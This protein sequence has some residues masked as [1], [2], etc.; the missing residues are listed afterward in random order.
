MT[1]ANSTK[2]FIAGR[3]RATLLIG[4]AIA[5]SATA[6]SLWVA[7][8]EGTLK[9]DALDG[10]VVLEIPEDPYGAGAVAVDPTNGNVWT[11]GSERLRGFDRDGV[12][13]LDIESSS[14]PLWEHPND[15]LVDGNAGNIWLN[16]GNNLYRL[17][18]SGEVVGSL[19][20]YGT[21]CNS[22][23]LDRE[24][25]RLWL[26]SYE[27]VKAYDAAFQEVVSLPLLPSDIICR[28][29]WDAFRDELWV[30]VNDKLRRYNSAGVT[31]FE[32]DNPA[33]LTNTN[34]LKPDGKGGL[35]LG[36][37]TQ[38]VY[39]DPTGAVGSWITP[40]HDFSYLFIRDAVVHP[41]DASIWIGNETHLRRFSTAGAQLQDRFLD[42]GDGNGRYLENMDIFEDQSKPIIEFSQPANNS[43]TNQ[44][45]PTL[46]LVFLDSG[47]GIDDDTLELTINE[48]PLA[49]SCTIDALGAECI[50]NAA[51][52]D[53]LKTV[54]ARISDTSGN[55]SDPATVR[56]TVDTVAP[57][58][59]VS[60]PANGATTNQPSIIVLGA[61]S[62]PAT[63]RINGTLVGL[64][65][66]NNFS[67]TAALQEGQNSLA[68]V[69]TDNATNSST[70]NRSV[71]LD[72]QAPNV[73]DVGFIGVSSPSGGLVTITGQAGSV[74]ANALVQV[75]NLRTG[76][77]VTVAAT[78]EG[79]FV[80]QIA[81]EDADQL[82]IRAID[83][84]QNTSNSAQAA[85]P[86]NLPPNPSTIATPLTTTGITPFAE[87]IAFLYS[88]PNPIQ[89]GV[90]T[91]TI[92]SEL[93]AVIRGSVTTRTG[94]PLANVVVAIK[95]HPEFGQ[96]R[97]RA[98]GRFDL[99]VNGG[100]VLTL[101]YQRN[102]YLPLHRNV[103]TS[104]KDYVLAG[105][106]V[107]IQVDTAVSEIALNTTTLQSHQSSVA[108]DLDGDRRITLMVPPGTTATM[109][110]PDG[111]T[112]P[113][114]TSMR[115]RATEYT[116][117]VNG[118]EAM[119]APLPPTSAYT[120]AVELSVDEAVAAGARRVD[121]NQPMPVYLENFLN[122]PVGTDVPVGYYDR[123]LATW[124][125]SDNG[126]V[127]RIIAISGGL[128]S[129][130]VD[131]SNQ[132][133]GP[134]ELT[135]LG[136]TSAER[137]RL[138][139]L[140][141][142]GASFWRFRVTHFTP[143][144]CNFP[145]DLLPDATAPP[146]F[147]APLGDPDSSESDECSG[148]TIDAHAQALGESIDI[149][150]TPFTIN[151]RSDRAGRA[152]S[153]VEF[154]I[155]GPQIAPSLAVVLVRVAIGG[156]D[157]YNDA[158]GSAYSE[159]RG[160]PT[161][162]QRVSIA[163]D[164]L[165]AYGRRMF[166]MQRVEI[167]VKYGYLPEYTSV[168]GQGVRAFALTSST[169]TTV[170]TY[171]GGSGNV[172]VPRL[173]FIERKKEYAIR[174]QTSAFSQLGG[175]TINAHHTLDTVGNTLYL[176]DG[177]RRNLDLVSPK[178]ERTLYGPFSATIAGAAF[179]P[180][181]G[182]A[183]ATSNGR[184]ILNG[185]VIAGG[186][187]AAPADNVPAATAIFPAMADV[188]AGPYENFHFI[189][190]NQVWRLDRVGN[191][192]RVAGTGE[193]GSAGDGGPARDAS[194][195]A[196]AGIAVSPDGTVFVSEPSTHR[197]R[198]VGPDGVIT[199]Y[200]GTGVGGFSGDGGAAL[201]AQLREPRALAHAVDGSLFVADTA[202]LRVRR[203][204]ATGTITTVA[205]NGSACADPLATC[206]DGGQATSAMFGAVRDVAVLP[207]RELLIADAGTRRVRAVRS[208][209]VI[210]TIAGSGQTWTTTPQGDQS[211]AILASLSDQITLG[212]DPVGRVYVGDRD[213]VRLVETPRSSQTVT[214]LSVASEDGRASYQF[215]FAGRH[216][217]TV[218]TLTG[219]EL[220]RFSYDP[221]G[222]ITSIRDSNDNIT[223]VERSAT[224]APVAIVSPYG[225]RTI[226]G[227][228][229]NGYLSSVEPPG[230]SVVQ[231]Q[232][233]ALGLLTRFTDARN[234]ASVYEYD[235]AGRLIRDTNP[236]DGGWEIVKTQTPSATRISM[237]SREGRTSEFTHEQTVNGGRTVVSQSS[238]G[239]QSTQTMS[240]SGY[241]YVL[242]DGTRTTMTYA[243]DPRFGMQAP[244]PASTTVR[245][246]SGL[247]RTKT[248]SRSVTLSNPFDPASI[249]SI[250][251]RS[252]LNGRESSATYTVANRQ[253]VATSAEGRTT[254]STFDALGRIASSSTAG[255]NASVMNYDARGR[256]ATVEA[257]SGAA[258]R[259][260]VFSYVAEGPAAGLVDTITD[261][262]GRV[263]RLEYDPAGRVSRQT[264]PGNRQVLYNHDANGNLLSITPPGRSAHV[265]DYSA[266]NLPTIYAPPAAGLP[267]SATTYAYNR[268]RQLTSVVRPGGQQMSFEYTA[269]GK[270]ES[271][272]T[273]RGVTT[274]SYNPATGQM[275][276]VSTPEGQA[277]ALTFDGFLPLSS[278]WSGPVS[279][280]VSAG[281][282]SD[283]MLSSISVNGSGITFAYDNDRL[284]TTAGS[285]TI[286]R[287]ASNGL[288]SG[289]ALNLVTTQSGYNGFGE[290]TSY[291]ASRPTAS[292]AET[293]DQIRSELT[294]LGVE[295]NTV[296]TLRNTSLA[297]TQ[298]NNL[299]SAAQQ[300]PLARPGFNTAHSSFRSSYNVLRNSALNQNAC[301][302]SDEVY[303]QIV[304]AIGRA[305]A[306][307]ARLQTL[308]DNLNSGASEGPVF[309]MQFLRDRLGRITSKTEQV[310]GTQVV[311]DYAYDSAGR[312][313]QVQTNG[314]VS[315]SYTYDAN[316]NRLTA[317]GVGATYDDQDRLL[318]LGSV[319]FTY[320]AN[321]DL[322]T[323]TQAGQT[324][325]YNYDVL[326][327][328]MG[329]Q[330]PDGRAVSYVVDGQ[331]RRVGKRINGALVQGYLY[332]GQLQL[333]AELDG[334]GSVV[335]R[336]VYGTKLTV[337][338]YM[339]RSG[340]TYR[341][342]SDHLGSP[343]LVINVSSGQVVQR[344][345][346]DSFGNVTADTNPGFQPFGFAG[347]LHDRDT[348]LIRFGSRDYD[349]RVGRWTAKDPILFTGG[350]QNLYGYT[351]ADPINLVDPT[352]LLIGGFLGQMLRP[353][354]GQTAQEAAVAG[355]ALDGIAGPTL[356][357]MFAGVPGLSH[358]VLVGLSAYQAV[359][360]FQ[361]ASLSLYV[362]FGMYGSGAA[363]VAFN[364]YALLPL[365]LAGLG[366]VELGLGLYELYY[367]LTGD[368]FGGDIYDLVQW[369][370][371]RRR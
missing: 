169:G 67:F 218:D 230:G 171:R 23:T 363:V 111:S 83:A 36:S 250:T 360:G 198:R 186:G 146:D 227:L 278:I 285:L 321:G 344:V 245:V 107:M 192:R 31:T 98:D 244:V 12:S 371:C 65:G 125:A 177:S 161:P 11:W 179:H 315:E 10:A 289:T 61:L 165:D 2:N 119:P 353:L 164:G 38:F 196:P 73:P 105:N 251:E 129:L 131:G 299:V 240:R 275:S 39:I 191:L 352:G 127:V 40:F 18:L 193:L 189:A 295:L 114:T 120:Y 4:C 290:L 221:A 223:V 308:V 291:S 56:F 369:F 148:C 208:N 101:D 287:S 66:T 78:A 124:I 52:A 45:R 201:Q 41:V 153:V 331:N 256:L 364:A 217:S 224:G 213:R 138:A 238:D 359:G 19:L 211:P 279:G 92:Q 195:S 231:M 366:G 87:S 323:R 28:A 272:T 21:T 239:T 370:N 145:Y 298:Y 25:S 33:G 187:T 3:L 47:S 143:W 342:I 254:Q 128:A 233:T 314:A 361:A 265:F 24:R 229:T 37:E 327:N 167:T 271:L 176:G 130:D 220:Y 26:C 225:Q 144:D 126:R 34:F 242:A 46:R 356:S 103:N 80:A 117:G 210:V 51:L 203:I 170:S 209:G 62:E 309:S 63:L 1:T 184:L 142:V 156:R 305:D 109:T 338:D 59:T 350:D 29:A 302:C 354:T 185:V 50:P 310:Q 100:G 172:L 336:F 53:G 30:A 188:A 91:G 274:Y 154:P 319:S 137:Q 320:T 48:A 7:E 180:R 228:D 199:T 355:R 94:Y 260:T 178:I 253:I 16:L 74:E 49:A 108:S 262:E 206:G 14:Y 147:D 345:D 267:T 261:A 168:L 281:Y 121:F 96:T 60:S 214:G 55:E 249:V 99:A 343:R 296:W 243:G 216:L 194:L 282:N 333:A 152:N 77:S 136:I 294:Q 362:T 284:L 160:V 72:T 162:N 116:V 326:G 134:Q 273:P 6:G 346:Y 328:L 155:T 322:Q 102:G 266:L 90:A 247:S 118:I 149:T 358:A 182:I 44:T 300:L 252:S 132:A 212:V 158:L 237:T 35:W 341:I 283:L 140:Y 215:D 293:I 367:L 157:I 276:G 202:N 17:N 32:M 173:I 57:Q 166:G 307:V 349:P 268:D 15:L 232:Y 123:A 70:L 258:L 27:S 79:A 325:T 303:A 226:L 334:S 280:T 312:L 163:W 112:Q 340:I 68:I 311:Y 190:G 151:Y 365:A 113:L 257:G 54:T 263:T 97:T 357:H 133:A 64:D 135:A 318:A 288:E 317:S 8:S 81:G 122:F 248:S 22:M 141:P 104:Q 9:L 301:E 241:E 207:S 88:G 43:A 351:L 93:A 264:L 348:G 84:A 150:G 13:F 175:W 335:S 5:L 313:A 292:E 277:V 316:G 159:A 82:Q 234:N 183:T 85:V 205:G 139:S 204:A 337:P 246:P 235:A 115:V 106:V 269:S 368:T 306:S 222:R 58:I 75:T 259:R 255:L 20:A 236:G 89:T 304:A 219:V 339:I 200:A 181:M 69:A 324:T 297:R 347:G 42:L 329:V 71:T 286:T 270:P 76:Q 174:A 110:L 95:D 330:L 332:Q 86:G 197:I